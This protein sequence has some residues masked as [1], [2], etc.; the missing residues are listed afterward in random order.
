MRHYP[1]TLNR[2]FLGIVG[3]IMLA[4]S[5]ALILTFAM[6]QALKM[7]EDTIQTSTEWIASIHEQT[8]IN[9]NTSWIGVAAV[10]IAVI[11][12]ILMLT[13]IF[14]QGGGKSR[15]VGRQQ[16][17]NTEGRTRTNIGF[18]R[19]IVHHELEDNQWIVGVGAQAYNVKGDDSILLRVSTHK[20]A[21]PEQ[22]RADVTRA[23][24]KLDSVLGTEP[25]ICVRIQSDW[26][27]I[28][29][30]AERVQ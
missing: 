8:I 20:G 23:I 18:V 2:L 1:R 22:V 30:S 24:Q 4:I 5:V 11:I 12:V 17:E 27:S 16:S 28:G 15:R 13:A 14:G 3:L 21:P 25:P 19:D 6:D 7:W 9:A 29:R 26:R 10:A